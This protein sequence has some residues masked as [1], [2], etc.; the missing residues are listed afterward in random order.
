M[1]HDRRAL[2]GVQ[3]PRAQADQTARRNRKVQMRVFA[4]AV[5]FDHLA[6]PCADQF[7]H[8]PHF[9]VRHFDHQRFERLFGHAVVLAQNH[10]RLA[11]RKLVAF[12]AHRFDQHRKMQQAAAGDDELLG[13]FERFDAQGPRFAPAPDPAVP[14]DA[15]W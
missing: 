15:A 14:A 11:D 9:F 2:R 4:A 1:M 3:Q 6:A 7:H 13:P 12:A 10:V 5:H 8:R